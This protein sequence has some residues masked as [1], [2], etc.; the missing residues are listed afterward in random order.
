MHQLCAMWEKTRD[1]HLNT[2]SEDIHFFNKHCGLRHLP[3]EGCVCKCHYVDAK[4][5]ICDDWYTPKWKST[6]DDNSDSAAVCSFPDYTVKNKLIRPSLDNIKHAISTNND[7]VLLC[8]AHYHSLYKQH[9]SLPPRLP[10]AAC[11]AMPKRGYSFNRHCPNPGTVSE[12]LQATAGITLCLDDTDN[13]CYACYK[14]HHKILEQQDQSSHDSA[15]V[16]LIH[17][18]SHMPAKN[19]LSNA[20]NKVTIYV[21]NHLLHQRALLLP[22]VSRYFLQVYGADP[23]ASMYELEIDT[24]ESIIQYSSRW[25]LG[26]LT[27]NIGIHMKYKCVHNRIGIVLYRHQG[28]LLTSLSYALGALSGHQ[29]NSLLSDHVQSE[30]SNLPEYKKHVLKKAAVIVNDAIHNESK[31]GA[32][33]KCDIESD[34]RG[35][36]IQALISEVDPLLWDISQ[37]VH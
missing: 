16:K 31:K 35:I 9:A 13:I 27:V 12:H 30:Y 29:N 28:E 3:R 36:N 15:L 5:H 1:V 24:G 7:D 23:L 21:A 25:L 32:S 34:P 18:A 14:F 6:Y 2:L 8:T 20:L 4:R 22:Q 26:H 11:G 19:K 33:R 10:C 17:D 37:S